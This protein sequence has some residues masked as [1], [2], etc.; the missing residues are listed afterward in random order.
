MT[1]PNVAGFNPGGIVDRIDLRDH[2]WS[3]VGFG[4]DP[5][6]WDIGSDIEAKVALSIQNPAFKFPVKDQGHTR[7]CG[8]QAWSAYAATL[9][10]IQSGSFEERS[11]KYVYSQTYAPGGGSA[12][13]DNSNILI[14]QGVARETVLP[15]YEN[16]GTP[17]E[18]FMERSQD[19]TDVI[20][21]D[22]VSSKAAS[23]ANVD[24]LID[25]V[26]QALRDNNGL[27]LGVRGENNGT[28][29]S[30]FPKPPVNPNWAHWVYAAK[31]KKI[32][33][34]KSIGFLNS[35]GTSTGDNGWQWLSED[36]F[37]KNDDRIFSVWTQVE[38]PQPTAPLFHH[39]F[40]T[41][42]KYGAS[43]SEVVALQTALKL[44]NCFPNNVPTSG[45]YGGV[46]TSAVIKFQVKYGIS[47]IGICGPKTR[48]QLNFIYSS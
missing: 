41:D 8:G 15:S 36:W 26:A 35:W 42:M 19:I 5:F 40:N 46:T 25:D 45:Y 4:S 1:D 27:V 39:T 2:K 14:K 31:A 17:S 18:T 20:R 30:A 12:G 24:S 48:A 10:G 28:W 34:A 9:E 7:S 43:G 47:P 11:A 44:N 16:G 37:N 23:Y 21:L 13:R 32:N 3:E 6:D 33:G 22:A 38:A 29:L